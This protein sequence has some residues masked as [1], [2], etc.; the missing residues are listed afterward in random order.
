[1]G[2]ALTSD[3]F[4]CRFIMVVYENKCL[5]SVRIFC[6]KNDQTIFLIDN[7]YTLF[8]DQSEVSVLP[9]GCL[10]FVVFML[11]TDRCSWQIVAL[12]E[13]RKFSFV[14]FFKFLLDTCPFLGPLI[15]LFQTSGDVSSGFQSQSGQPYSNFFFFFFL[16]FLLDTCPFVGP[17][18]PLFWTSGDVSSGFQSQSGFCLIRTWRRY[19]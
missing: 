13:K 17:L 3:W 6:P 15:P 2:R 9:V 11:V 19:T 10:W 8:T 16:I 4:V 7:H 12:G 5:S 1:M 18:I 14:F